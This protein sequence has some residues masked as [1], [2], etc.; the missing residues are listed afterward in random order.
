MDFHTD[1]SALA[2]VLAVRWLPIFLVAATVHWFLLAE[3][4]WRTA[5]VAAALLLEIG[6]AFAIMYAPVLDPSLRLKM[7]VGSNAIGGIPAVAALLSALVVTFLLLVF[8]RL[9]PRPDSPSGSKPL[10]G[11]V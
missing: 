8:M 1:Y 3:R 2:A 7:I 10:G 4:R 5:G 11:S 6:L 9:G